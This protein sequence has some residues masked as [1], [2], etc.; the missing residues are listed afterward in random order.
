MQLHPLARAGAIFECNATWWRD[1]RVEA[2]HI[3]TFKSYFVDKRA[4]PLFQ[5]DKYATR[6]TRHKECS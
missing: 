1:R 6:P 2:G 5:A 3:V 4:C